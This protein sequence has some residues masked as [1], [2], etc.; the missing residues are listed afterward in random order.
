MGSFPQESKAEEEIAENASPYILQYMFMKNPTGF[1]SLVTEG[2]S[3]R[4]KN[5]KGF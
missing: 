5:H 2:E 1:E 4:K 3:E